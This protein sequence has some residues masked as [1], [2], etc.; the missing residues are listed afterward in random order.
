[1]V[2]PGNAGAAECDRVKGAPAVS[3][4]AQA[5]IDRFHQI[6]M[7][8]GIAEGTRR[9]LMRQ[10]RAV[11]LQVE[12]RPLTEVLRPRLISED[13]HKRVC[14]VASLLA[15][16]LQ[17]LA[18]Y[19]LSDSELGDQVRHIL[20]LT[21]VEL[22]LTGM[23][24]PAD[25][26]SRHSRLDGFFTADRLAFVEY[27]AHSPVGPLTQESLAEIFLTTP[28]MEAFVEGY[29]V[30]ASPARQQMVDCLV[31]A[32]RTG[33]MPG[34]GP[35]VAI[36]ECGESQFS[37]EFDMLR[38]E[39]LRHGVPAIICSVDDLC[40]GPGRGGLYVHDADGN[41]YPITIVHRRAVL[42][43]LLSRYGRAFLDHP[44]TRAWSSGACVMVNSFTAHLANKKSAL[45]LLTDPRTSEALS[46]QELA[47]AEEHLPWTRL[48][49]PG[50]TTYHGEEVDLLPFACAHRENLVLKPNDDYGGHGIVC[51][52]QV[53]HD[54]WEKELAQAADECYV[55]QERVMMPE[56]RYP[57]WAAED[58]LIFED[59]HE[60]TDPFLFASTAY[61]FIC[62]LSPTELINISAGGTCVPAFQ[63]ALRT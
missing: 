10:Q 42:N 1:M 25:Q 12:E 46:P 50:P 58:G 51:G 44:L 9:W 2:I 31:D 38:A 60:G 48:L 21:P 29:C 20:A 5:A 16:A 28:A 62:R 15:E 36:V 22:A 30:R 37:W 11:G 26:G 57:K 17:R 52:W 32:W 49:R 54:D 3:H 4:M 41:R 61:G 34:D 47:A 45:A 23:S 13:D 18:R 39:L 40:F 55:I 24:P 7:E 27:N 33:G 43:D 8:G 56:V 53:A 59:Y 35:R 19:G 63:V 14:S 6:L